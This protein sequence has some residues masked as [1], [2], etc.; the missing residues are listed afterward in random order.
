MGENWILMKF[1]ILDNLKFLLGR[2]QDLPIRLIPRARTEKIL[3]SASAW[4]EFHVS[5]S[6]LAGASL[7]VVSALVMQNWCVHRKS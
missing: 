7:E 6:V 4:T 2:A 5:G 1:E 3:I